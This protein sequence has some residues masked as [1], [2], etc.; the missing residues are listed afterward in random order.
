MTELIQLLRTL[1]WSSLHFFSLSSQ[2]N[3]STKSIIER[4][5]KL[6]NRNGNSQDMQNSPSPSQ[7]MSFP[8]T[9]F[10]WWI[11]ETVGNPCTMCFFFSLPWLGV[12]HICC[13]VSWSANSPGRH[14][15]LR[16]QELSMQA[17]PFYKWAT[18]AEWLYHTIELAGIGLGDRE[19][20]RHTQE[21]W[22]LL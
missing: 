12:G 13:S 18:A 2:C 1:S 19:E 9:P 20:W 4:Q 14:G 16:S 11:C 6:L 7:A 10:P 8:L 21:A 15:L 17:P 3:L 5:Y 22:D